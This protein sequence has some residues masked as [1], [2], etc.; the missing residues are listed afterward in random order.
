MAWLTFEV[1][2]D[3]GQMRLPCEEALGGACGRDRTYDN[4]AE[5]FEQVLQSVGN[6]RHVLN[7]EDPQTVQ[8]H[9]VPT[10]R[11]THRKKQRSE[12]PVSDFVSI[13]GLQRICNSSSY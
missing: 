7:N 10:F 3:Q 12:F 11:T 5:F 6:R 9:D 1:H 13:C 4:H 2:V 8:T